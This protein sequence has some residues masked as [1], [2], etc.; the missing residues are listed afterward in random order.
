MNGRYASHALHQVPIGA[1]R[2]AHRSLAADYLWQPATTLA[3]GISSWPA[4]PG[5]R[6]G[7]PDLSSRDCG[8]GLYR[9]LRQMSFA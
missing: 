2:A 3:P 4:A 9:E 1:H 5:S 7:N 8:H 6:A